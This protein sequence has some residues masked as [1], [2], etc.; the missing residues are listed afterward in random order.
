MY[1]YF[2]NVTDADAA[3][4]LRWYT[5]K[6]RQEI[7]AIEAA[8]EAAPHERASQR[9]IAR[10]M[11]ARMHSE[12][13]VQRVEQAAEALFGG[14][15]RSIDAEMLDA[16]FADV[17]TTTHA[18]ASLE[19]DGVSLAELLPET[20][21]AGSRREAREFLRNGSVAINGEKVTGE[22][23]QGRVLNAVDL[24]HGSVILL[25]RG[26]KAWHATRWQ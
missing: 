1:Q 9:A 13:S 25:K 14:D 20:S 15:I 2:L 16:V 17:P 12:A 19:G 5:F 10:D 18:A 22:E 6:D 23:A 7:E 11:T 24:L 21:L 4:F 26:K 8:H 3:N